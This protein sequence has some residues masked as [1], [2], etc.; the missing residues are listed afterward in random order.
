[1]H[2]RIARLLLGCGKIAKQYKHMVER[3]KLS[4]IAAVVLRIL[5]I[6][7]D[8]IWVVGIPIQMSA[9]NRS[10]EELVAT[11]SSVSASCAK[12]FFAIVWNACSTLIASLADVS[13]Y[14]ILPLAWHH[15]IARFCETYK[16]TVRQAL[17][18]NTSGHSPC[19]WT[20]PCRSCCQERR[21]GNSR[22]HEGKPRDRA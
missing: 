6:N 19:A 17:T 15:C 4:A 9:T 20:P 2:I 12:A 22:D 7:P 21:M 1:M 14:G 8:W 16:R 10:L 11:D 18:T 3:R 13:K 5:R